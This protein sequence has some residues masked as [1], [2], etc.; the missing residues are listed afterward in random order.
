MNYKK[1]ID[2][3]WTRIVFPNLSGFKRGTLYFKEGV[4]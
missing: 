3:N 2:T 4:S 1:M